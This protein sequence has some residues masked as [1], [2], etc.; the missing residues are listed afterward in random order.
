MRKRIPALAFLPVLLSAAHAGEE[1][2][3]P[4]AF[5]TGG[6]PTF[7]AGTA[8]DDASDRK[9]RAQIELVR[10]MLFPTAPVMEDDAI[11]VEKGPAAWPPRPVVYG[12][13]HVNS[14]VARLA[15]LLPFRLEP[16]KLV[17]GDSVFVGEEI[18]LVTVVPG[19][20][21]TDGGPGHPPFLLYAGAGTP[22]IAEINATSHGPHGF[23]VADRFGP[24]TAGH[25]ERNAAGALA[26]RF[27]G[28]N[29]RIEWRAAGPAEGLTVLRPEMIPPAAGDAEV[30]AACVRAVARVR[31]KLA[32]GGEGRLLVH[33]YPDR[34]SKR[35][36]TGD[37]GDGRADILSRSVHVLPFDASEGGPLE[38]LLAH[39]A[40]HVLAYDAWGA[41]GSTLF[42]EGLAVWV[43]GSYGG[44]SLADRAN[45]PPPDVPEVVHLLGPAFRKLPERTSYPLAGILTGTVVELVGLDRFRERIYAATPETWD[46][47]CRAAGTT[48]A[49]VQAAFERALRSG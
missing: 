33:V 11:E 41:P 47:A 13:P 12:G 21:A 9:I 45:R 20:S 5:L 37:G 18:R 8:G 35:S 24:L 6:P 31:R 19:R 14:V 36:L 16:G 44:R 43:S 7:V 39:E 38:S 48:A 29:R 46:E 30:D 2:T 1:P 22:G 4:N 40:T 25:W 42:G 27:L 3:T 10:G 23:L 34:G 49:A 17:I 15:P 28:R 32:L 26:A